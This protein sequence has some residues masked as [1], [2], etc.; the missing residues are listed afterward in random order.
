MYNS[1]VPPTFTPAWGNPAAAQR[2]ASG[3]PGYRD[4]VNV[5]DDDDMQ[6]DLGGDAE[7]TY[8]FACGYDSAR[9]SSGLCKRKSGSSSSPSDWNPGGENS[10]VAV[11]S[12]IKRFR[13]ST[14]PG[15]IRLQKDLQELRELQHVTLEYGDDPSNVILQFKADASAHCPNRFS[16]TVKRFYP[17]DPPLILCLDAGFTSPFISEARVV[18]HRALSA[19]WSALGSVSTIL[20]AVQQVREEYMQAASSGFMPTPSLLPSPMLF[21][22]QHQHQHQHQLQQQYQLDHVFSRG[23]RAGARVEGEEAEGEGE[24]EEFGENEGEGGGMDAE[25]EGEGEI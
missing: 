21:Q 11:S 10:A 12:M 5:I 18:Q 13:I 9:S 3:H 25:G 2:G 6:E 4:G 24:G 8:V 15:E 14:T 19:E 23:G 1:G 20:H 22:H 17:H 16:I 7:E